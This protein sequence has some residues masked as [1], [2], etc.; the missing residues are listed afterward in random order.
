MQANVNVLATVYNEEAF[1]DYSIRS[2]LPYVKSLTVVEGAYR[3]SIAIG[4]PPR[5]TDRTQ[6]IINS[7]SGHK[8]SSIEANEKSDAHQRNVGLRHILKTDPNGWLLIID[9]DE[10]YDPIT[11][12]MIQALIGK[13]NNCG[14]KAAYFKSLTFVNDLN[15]YTEQEFPRLFKLSPDC[16][17]VNDN[18]MRWGHDTNFG[19][20]NVIRAPNIKFYHYSFCKGNERFALKKKWWE[21]RF[22]QH[23]DYSWRLDEDGKISDRGHIIRPFLGRHPEVMKGHPLY[24]VRQPEDSV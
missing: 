14:A 24:G 2:Y 8:V 13:M 9:G 15:Y 23:F 6:R 21:T 7:Y 20:P 5:S 4:A 19:P 18:Y 17:F 10:V 12:R 11:F 3:E 16:T 1:L 22:N